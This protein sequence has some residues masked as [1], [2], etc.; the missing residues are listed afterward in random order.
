MSKFTEESRFNKEANFNLVK[1]GYDSPVLE[2]ELNELQEILREKIRDTNRYSMDS[3]L[4]Y[5]NDLNFTGTDFTIN[6]DVIIVDGEILFV[7]ENMTVSASNNDDI[8]I[9]IW[10]EEVDKDD[11]LYE[12]GN[13]D[14][15]NTVDNHILDGRI[16]EETTRRYQV[17]FNLFTDDSDPNKTFVKICEI[18][19][20]GSIVNINYSYA[21]DRV[22]T[23]LDDLQE[24]LVLLT[25]DFDPDEVTGKFNIVEYPGSI[26]EAGKINL[27]FIDGLDQL[28]NKSDIGIKDM[29]FDGEYL[30]LL[31]NSDSSSVP[32]TISI[33]DISTLEIIKE[34][35]I[36]DMDI[37]RRE[38]SEAQGNFQYTG[39]SI[40]K[41]G[42][43]L[44]TASGSNITY[45]STTEG[46]YT[47]VRYALSELL[48]GTAEY[49]YDKDFGINWGYGDTP[50]EP[51]K[52]K[53]LTFI[54]GEDKLLFYDGIDE[55]INMVDIDTETID[56]TV[57][58]TDVIGIEHHKNDIWVLDNQGTNTHTLTRYEY[59]S[60]ADG[61]IGSELNSYCINKVINRFNDG[62]YV[63][64]DLRDFNSM[65]FDGV[66]LKIYNWI[67]PKE[68][69]EEEETL[70]KGV[71]SDLISDA[72]WH[73]IES[74]V[75]YPIRVITGVID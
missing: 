38:G 13:Q 42:E 45:G 12:Y 60:T 20:G 75:A 61:G 69:I 24:M 55:E 1:F 33:I 8:F 4:I 9:G 35:D 62:E 59:S 48:D 72:F 22:K 57:A 15:I 54:E 70:Y 3:G 36:G 66:Y 11:T 29:A 51:D 18:D 43:Y 63:H 6:N 67:K 2:V 17:K 21:K 26:K 71:L 5:G 28:T 16:N 30:W 56:S 23:R 19:N 74:V 14:T 52:T 34:I 7:T 53:Y 73:R 58:V 47:F 10:E 40:D 49:S 31:E 65:I 39:I 44:W 68:Y 37:P 27:S 32:G 46:H 25:G 64:E 41:T 50:Y